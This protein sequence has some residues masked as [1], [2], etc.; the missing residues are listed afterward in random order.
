MAE[1]SYHQLQDSLPFEDIWV[2]EHLLVAPAELSY[3]D[4]RELEDYCR[5]VDASA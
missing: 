2:I 5:S 1:F 4:A 3:D